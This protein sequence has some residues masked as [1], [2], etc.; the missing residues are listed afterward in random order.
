MEEPHI[1]YGGIRARVFG[2]NCCLTKHPMVRVS[3]KLGLAPHPHCSTNLYCAD[4]SLLIRHYKFAGDFI[5][6]TRAS[7]AAGTWK[8]GE[9]VRRLAQLD[10]MESIVLDTPFA[11]RLE[12]PQQLYDEGFLIT[13]DSLQSYAASRSE[14]TKTAS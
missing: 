8:H 2:E 5:E 1:F 12:G 10:N 14:G 11:R 6:R 4:I 9:D 3:N 7:V 13:S